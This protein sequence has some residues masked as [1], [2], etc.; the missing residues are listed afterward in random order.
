[1]AAGGNYSV[2]STP[3]IAAYTTTDLDVRWFGA[4]NWTSS[5][6][7]FDQWDVNGGQR[8][9]L[10]EMGGG[11]CRLSFSTTGAN[12]YMSTLVNF[13]FGVGAN[14]GVRFTRL[15]SS[16]LVRLY[17]STDGVNWVESVGG[18]T[19]MAAGTAMFASTAALMFGGYNTNGV[20]GQIIGDTHYAELRNG[21]D[22]AVV[23]RH[24]PQS[25]RGLTR[26]QASWTCETGQ[27]VTRVGGANPGPWIYPTV[28]VEDLMDLYEGDIRTW[29]GGDGY[30][31]LPVTTG[32]YLSIPHRS[33]FAI[34]GDICIVARIYRVAWTGATSRVIVSRWGNIDGSYRFGIRNDG[35]LTFTWSDTGTGSTVTTSTVSLAAITPNTWLFLAVSF[36][37][38]SGADRQTKFWTSA[39]NVNWTQLGATVTAAGGATSIFAGTDPLRVGVLNGF[40]SNCFD[41]RVGYLSIRDGIGAG[42]TVGG[43]EVF[44][45]DR[46]SFKVGRRATTVPATV[47]VTNTKSF[48]NYGGI[49]STPDTGVPPDQF[50]L[51]AELTA[52]LNGSGGTIKTIASHG[53][54]TPNYAWR[55]LFIDTSTTAKSVRVALSADGTA[56]TNFSV[57]NIVPHNPG[58]HYWLAQSMEKVGANWTTIVYESEDGTT[59]TNRGTAT[60]AFGTIF[61]TAADLQI[62]ASSGSH[63]ADIHCIEMRTGLDPNAGTVLWKLDS[64]E[65]TMPAMTY[66]Q[67]GVTDFDNDGIADGWTTW[68]GGTVSSTKREVINGIQY[69]EAVLESN[70]SYFGVTS[71]RFPVTNGTTY[72]CSILWSLLQTAPSC[73]FATRV[74][75]YDA[76]GAFVTEY[77]ITT[78]SGGSPTYLS[79][80]SD[81]FTVNIPTIVSAAV[82]V[83]IRQGYTDTPGVTRAGFYGLRVGP[84]S[85]YADPRGRTWS[86]TSAGVGNTLA[87]ES[88]DLTVNRSGTPVLQIY[89]SVIPN[90]ARWDE[91]QWDDGTDW[92]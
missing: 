30:A 12:Q 68:Q 74:Y 37:V 28:D 60:A 66:R 29:P 91:A 80:V 10:M 62:G 43:T 11:Q 64:D 72:E 36:D 90:P 63:L 76:V 67:S 27:V 24:G 23:F 83:G 59:W 41:G 33:E 82:C 40:D 6:G 56:V 61:D 75:T 46:D 21:I 45:L 15:Q 88:R 14:G 31:D 4:I 17:F 85:S 34:I 77:V 5:A 26:K 44:H 92:S 79:D 65:S 1:M 86:T 81:M 51:I 71:P 2:V 20:S 54:S 35:Y 3:A 53:P 84:A 16:G 13:P 8:A 18:Q 22:G 39:D 78:I 70:P 89:P 42:N 55:W 25:L 73:N 48:A 57:A 32:N 58:A 69:V 52:G 87:Y 9:W 19:V 38:V 7:I 50:I 49:V 47:Q